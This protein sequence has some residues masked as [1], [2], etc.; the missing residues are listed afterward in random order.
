MRH[1]LI[2][3]FP[4]QEI[5]VDAAPCNLAHIAAAAKRSPAA[6]GWRAGHRDLAALPGQARSAKVALN[7]HSKPCGTPRLPGIA[8]TQAPRPQVAGYARLLF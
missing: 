8:S 7:D 3:A 4:A 1:I 2:A 6:L 5:Q